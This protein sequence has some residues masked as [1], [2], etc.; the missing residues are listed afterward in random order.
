MTDITADNLNTREK[1][2]LMAGRSFWTFGGVERLGIP[3]VKTTDASNGIREQYRDE[4][5]SSKPG[6]RPAL[7]YPSLCACGCSFDK[8]LIFEMGRALGEECKS[9]GIAVLLGP[10][11][12]IKRNPLCGRNFEYISED[13]VLSGQLGAAFIKGVQSTGVAACPKHLALNNQETA[14]TTVDSVADAKTM[15]ELYL[16]SF[17][18]AVRD[19]QPWVIMGAYNKLNGIYCCENSWLLN[20]VL[21]NEWGFD[22]VTVSD[23]GGVNDIIRS[24]NAGLDVEMPGGVNGDI[25]FISACAE[26]EILRES[27]MNRAANDILKLTGRTKGVAAKS[28]YDEN[29]HLDIIKKVAG[30]SFVLLKNDDDILPVDKDAKVLVVGEM[31]KHPRYQGNGSGKVKLSH[32]STPWEHLKKYYRNI[33]FEAGYNLNCE[34]DEQKAQRAVD[35]CADADVVLFFAGQSEESES[36]GMDRDDI[37][38]PMEHGRLI[39]AIARRNKNIAVIV[40]GGSCVEMFW[41]DDVKA[42]LMCYFP[43]SCFGDALTDVVSG[44]VNPS[45]KLAETFPDRLSD[46]P[47][48][49][50]FP[51][52][53]YAVYDEGT[54]A[55]Y[56]YYNKYNINVAYPFGHGLSYTEFKFSGIKAHAEADKIKAGCTVKNI[57]ARDGKAV[58]QIY[59]KRKE[60]DDAPVLAAFDTIYLDAGEE[61]EAALEINPRY[62]ARYD[63]DGNAFILDGG[64]YEITAGYSSVSAAD[65]TE[66]VI[67]DNL[68][69]P[70]KIESREKSYYSGLNDEQPVTLNSTLRDFE[71]YKAMKPVIAIVKA[72]SRHFGNSIVPGGKIA[73][74]IMDTP[75]RQL[76]MGTNGAVSIVQI[77]KAVAAV[78]AIIA[79]KNSVSRRGGVK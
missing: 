38:L 27:A 42:I 17:E 64:A 16:R 47:S 1:I 31:A 66:L 53:G 34:E 40:Q 8:E 59:I 43:G 63:E 79:A 23:W 7:C 22:G 11:I 57:G 55:G 68:I 46:V 13:P 29:E 6:S 77:K 69:Y 50:S 10:G 21:R 32:T 70:F 30:E 25:E 48:Y 78:N 76:P 65:K 45:G 2:E 26:K 52:R 24:F 60:G 71:K 20:D 49:E 12:N 51:S 4:G 5:Y 9:R 67:E 44:K 39:K 15:W 14:R 74:V 62:I 18:I 54:L 72:V 19:G 41:R 75:L 35:A 56:R 33:S 28:S 3:P 36:E 61:K 58:V 73:E 37:K